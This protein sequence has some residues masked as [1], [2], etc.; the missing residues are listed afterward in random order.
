M[1]PQP[2]VGMGGGYLSIYGIVRMCVPS[3]PFFQRCQVY[4]WPFFRQKYVIDPSFSWLIYKRAHFSDVSRYMH[5]S[6]VQRFSEAACFLGNQLIDC[7]ICLTTSNKWLQKIKGQYM[8]GS[9]FQTI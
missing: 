3:G 2:C 4:D 9:T 7:G 5:I 6:F 1:C 8:N